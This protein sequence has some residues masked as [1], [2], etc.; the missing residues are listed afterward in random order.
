MYTSLPNISILIVQNLVQ[1]LQIKSKNH[2]FTLKEHRLSI[3]TL[4]DVIFSQDINKSLDFDSISF[5]IL[6]VLLSFKNHSYMNPIY[7]SIYLKLLVL[8][9]FSNEL[10]SRT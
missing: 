2:L 7:L 8:L 3:N 9:Q 1:T 6:I 4:K 10:M 5:T